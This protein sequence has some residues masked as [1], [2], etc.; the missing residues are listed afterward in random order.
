MVVACVCAKPNPDVLV[1]APVVAAATP[2]A[3]SSVSFSREFHAPYVAA[4]AY[5]YVA[6]YSSP[7]VAAAPYSAYASRILL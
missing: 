5:P 2:L 4:A 1:G 3:T 6:A 7:Y